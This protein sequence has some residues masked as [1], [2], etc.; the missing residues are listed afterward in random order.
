[1]TKVTLRAAISRR[2]KAQ[3]AE[4]IVQKFPEFSIPQDFDQYCDL[5]EKLV[6]QDNDRLMRIAFDIYDFNQDKTV[7]E[8][9]TYAILQIFQDPSS[10]AKNSSDE[11]NWDTAIAATKVSKPSQDDEVYVS[12][13]SYDLCIIGQALQRKRQ[14]MGI[15]DY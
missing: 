6:N 1:M 3:I 2:F 13:F 14:Q 11:F 4:R 15:Q 7:C 12:A 8:L 5:I 9:D 10:A